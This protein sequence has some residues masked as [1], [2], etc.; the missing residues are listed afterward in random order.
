M[1][2]EEQEKSKITKRWLFFA[3]AILLAGVLLSGCKTS[4]SKGSGSPAPAKDKS[5][6]RLGYVRGELQHLPFH[7]AQKK[8]FFDGQELSIEGAVAYEG[9]A[10]VVAALISGELDAAY[11]DAIDVLA[12]AAAGDVQMALIAQ[13]C[14]GGCA[15]VVRDGETGVPYELV[16]KAVAM[17]GPATSASMLLQVF[18]RANKLDGR[19]YVMEVEVSEMEKALAAERRIDGFVAWEPFVAKAVRL[20]NV[21]IMPTGLPL[22]KQM[23]GACLV[24]RRTY[25]ERHRGQVVKLAAAHR[26]ATD[27]IAGHPAQAATLGATALDAN[28]QV[29]SD[30]LGRLRFDARIDAQALREVA[31]FLK[32]S[33]LARL[34]SPDTLVD[35][36][37]EPALLVAP[38]SP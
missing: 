28:S 26:A 13:S 38:D 15:L 12:T 25:L 32:D 31:G 11:V 21:G 30:A 2:V 14:H 4:L 10:E 16:S 37:I 27:W 7:V 17:P 36:L 19:V 5:G 20:E 24:V 9:G 8:G 22:E 18:L 1:G 3:L 6:L 23:P 29:L 33:N 35:R 34:A